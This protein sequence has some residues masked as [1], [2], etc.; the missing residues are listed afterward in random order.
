VG[1]PVSLL[2]LGLGNVLCGDDGLGPAALGLLARRYR[3]PAGVEVVDGGT[4][5]LSLLDY[6]VEARAAILVDA[7][8]ADASP[9]AL[10][11]LEGRAVPPAVADRLSPHQ[12]GVADLLQCAGWLGR[13]PDPLI[14]VGLVPA[15]VALGLGRSPA[16]VAR[17]PAL[18]ECVVAEARRLGHA[19]A[20][21]TDDDDAP[22]RGARDVARVLGL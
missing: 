18:V 7:I 19:F 9:G 2:V 6:V 10:V 15:T 13:C 12:V 3:A 21:R 4:L 17:L 8:R 1:E 5:G 14:L 16:V 11:R 22:A 20:P